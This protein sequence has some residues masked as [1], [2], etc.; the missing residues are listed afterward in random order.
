MNDLITQPNLKNEFKFY[1]IE[2]QTSNDKG[3]VWCQELYPIK[4]FLNPANYS[5]K[6]SFKKRLTK[7]MFLMNTQKNN[8]QDYKIG[9][10]MLRRIPS[11]F[12]TTE[13]IE[14]ISI[15]NRIILKF[16]SRNVRESIISYLEQKEKLHLSNALKKMAS[17]T[18]GVGLNEYCSDWAKRLLY[19][20]G[21]V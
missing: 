15:D 10:D 5:K 21:Q 9:W 4:E 3:T 1:Y 11:K 19:D 2:W 8:F 20:C 6:D 17:K 14:E 13:M 18:G 7:F 12:Y 16:Y